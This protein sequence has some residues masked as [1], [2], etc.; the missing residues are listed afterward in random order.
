MS[1]C[2]EMSLDYFLKSFMKV[3][4]MCSAAPVRFDFSKSLVRLYPDP[5]RSGKVKV[6]VSFRN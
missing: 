2:Y 4:A 6:D 3:S 5:D 1:R